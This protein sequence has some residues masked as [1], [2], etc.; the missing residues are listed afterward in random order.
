MEGCIR[1]VEGV[2][3]NYV[4]KIVSSMES[5]KVARETLKE[6]CVILAGHY[7]NSKYKDS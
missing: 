6:I 4:P 1:T 3:N 5:N 2:V 7:R